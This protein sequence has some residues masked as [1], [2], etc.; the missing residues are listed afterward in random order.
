MRIKERHRA[1]LIMFALMAGA[2]AMYLFNASNM[3]FMDPDEARCALIARNMLETG[4]WLVPRI[5]YQDHEAYFDKPVLYF[6]M[7]AGT[8]RA[9]GTT[10]FAARLLAALAGTLVVGGTYQLGRLLLSGRAGL[11]ASMMLATSALMIIAGRFVRMDM[12]LTAFIVWG[13]YFWCRTHFARGSAWNLLLAYACLAAAVLTKGLIGMLLPFAVAGTLILIQRDWSALRRAHLLSGLGLI[14]LLAGPWYAYM[15]WRFPGYAMEFF[16]K[17]HFLRASTGTFGRSEVFLF[18]PGIALAGFLPWTAFLGMSLFRALPKRINH[19]W[20][21]NDGSVLCYCWAAWGVIP[22]AFSRTQLPIYIMPAFP[23][24][25]LMAGDLLDRLFRHGASTETRWLMRTT[26]VL[27]GLSLIAMALINEYTFHDS[28]VVSALRRFAVFVPLAI[29]AWRF[30]NRGQFQRC[31]YLL[32]GLAIMGGIDAARLEGPGMFRQFSSHRFVRP[33][34][35]LAGHVDILV[36]G[37]ER[38]F[39]L[40]FYLDSPIEIRFVQHVIDFAEYTS[41]PG[42]VAALVTSDKLIW[43]ARSQFGDRLHLLDQRGNTYLIRIDPPDPQPR[44]SRSQVQSRP[45]E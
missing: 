13:V 5:P 19:N 37:P 36:I 14:L 44:F 21:K 30:T 23:A 3:V 45:P 27:M 7:L 15:S 31:W 24:L 32:L 39:A 22:F 18:L 1:F 12:W 35:E 38:K 28:P 26:L 6:W 25:A 41:Y 11:A 43:L 40:P 34:A 17:H 16:W 8:F 10:E 42:T 29:L 33:M 20:P 9:L 4:D 2:F